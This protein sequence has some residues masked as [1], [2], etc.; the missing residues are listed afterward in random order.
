[1]A[2]V[3]DYV[4]KNDDKLSKQVIK[5]PD[6]VMTKPEMAQYLVSTID[7]KDDDIVMEP[8]LGNGAFYDSFPVSEYNKVWCEIN[9]GI[10]YLNY[11]G[12]VDYTISNPPFV[13]RKLFWQF[14]QKAMETT[15]KGIYWLVNM[16]SLN[17]FTPKRL[18]EMN[19]KGWY[20]N[21]FIIVA[22][23]RW[24]GRYCFLKIT[25]ENNNF[26]LFHKKTF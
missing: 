3:W 2:K 18:E 16:S 23:K 8:C 24:F 15:N 13:P 7:F 26:V 17:V 9:R 5:N 14:H 4:S 1:M 21:G 10:D 22:D 19:D 6:I 25:K 20:I 11:D 12:L